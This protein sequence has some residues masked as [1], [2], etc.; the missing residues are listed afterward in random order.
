[1][2]ECDVSECGVSEYDVSDCDV[3]EC[4]VSECDLQT[5][6]MWRFR[7]TAAVKALKKV[8]RLHDFA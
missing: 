7:N 3:S 4:G 1:M 2:S 5:S 6:T 8:L